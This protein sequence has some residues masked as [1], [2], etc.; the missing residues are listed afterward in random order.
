MRPFIKNKM[1]NFPSA[2][3]VARASVWIFIVP[4]LNNMSSQKSILLLAFLLLWGP[5]EKC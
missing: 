2:L 5:E 4:I 1:L 3:E